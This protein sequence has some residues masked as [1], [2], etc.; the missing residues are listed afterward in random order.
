MRRV[1]RRDGLNANQ[2]S[3][4]RCLARYRQTGSEAGLALARRQAFFELDLRAFRHVLGYQSLN[5]ARTNPVG[6]FCE[7]S[8]HANFIL[9]VKNP[10]YS[11][12]LDLKTA[13]VEQL[14]LVLPA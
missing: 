1:A 11:E 9:L 10:R 5:V 13:S 6:R 4:W 2:L 14:V 7:N 3:I 12:K 8:G